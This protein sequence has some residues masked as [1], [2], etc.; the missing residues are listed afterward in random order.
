MI[1]RSTHYSSPGGDTIQV[2]MTAKYLRLLGVHVDIAL[3]DKKIDPS[4]YDL[5][6]FFNIIRPD[7]ILSH[8]NSK[9]PYVI[10]TIFVDFSKYD[11]LARK[12]LSGKLF[13]VLS[14]W[15]IEYLKSMARYLIKGD[16]IKSRYYLFSGQFKSIL[17]VANRAKLLLPNSNSEYLRLQKAL[18]TS[19]P[20]RK[21]VNA[22]DPSIFKGTIEENKE[23]KDHIIC[24]GRIEGRKNQLNLI[25]A[26][27]GTQY[28]LTIIGK[29]A[30]NQASYYKEC[31]REASNSPKIR[32]IDH[33]GQKDL[34]PIYKAAKVH[35]LA[36]WFETTGLSSLEAAIMNCN[37]V[38]TK[39]GDTEEYF[40]DMAYYCEPDD[41]QSIKEAIVKAFNAPANEQLK[42]HILEN[43][44]WDKAAEQTLEAYKVALGI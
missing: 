43:Y 40:G 36:S 15:Q 23:F 13:K 2:E 19:Y 5:V 44:N 33:I 1:T 17:N 32:F 27:K 35:V 34:V 24:V 37:I 16:K 10:S 41:V 8:I 39:K 3:A 20:Y 4:G 29:P 28:H 22:V 21:I 6:H 11:K 31:L 18:R 26:V 7:D 30:P 42:T 38:I 9:V 14:P 25:K 12:G